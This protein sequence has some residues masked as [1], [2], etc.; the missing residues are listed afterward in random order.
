MINEKYE[1]DY[2]DLTFDNVID[3]VNAAMRVSFAN[4]HKQ[5]K[6]YRSVLYT[7]ATEWRKSTLTV[8]QSQEDLVALEARRPAGCVGC[9]RP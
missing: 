3:A 1:V 2:S 4:G 8:V 7:G 9:G 6:V 5:F